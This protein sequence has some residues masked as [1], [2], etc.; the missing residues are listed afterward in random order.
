L[1]SEGLASYALEALL[2]SEAEQIAA[3]QLLPA[4]IPY[5]PETA[6]VIREAETLLLPV[7]SNIAL[8]LHEGARSDRAREYARTWLLDGGEQIDQ[9][10]INIEA[11]SWRLYESCYPVGLAVCRDYA[12]TNESRF[13]DLL[14][15]QLTPANLARR[16]DAKKAGQA[17][18]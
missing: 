16:S 2:G 7:R 17:D 14:E 1:I 4:G 15:R 9:A 12:D 8:M 5:D 13:Q 11:R 10:I 3:E 18:T 6:A